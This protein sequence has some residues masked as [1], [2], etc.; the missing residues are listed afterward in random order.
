MWDFSSPTRIEP[1]PSVLGVWNPSHWTTREVPESSILRAAPKGLFLQ[2]FSK[3]GT[4]GQS[5]RHC[6]KQSFQWGVGLLE[7]QRIS[8]VGRK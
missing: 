7:G 5:H 4:K 2:S 3:L 8:K 6:A 1:R